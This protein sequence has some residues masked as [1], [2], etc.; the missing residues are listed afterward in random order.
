MACWS[1]SRPGDVAGA[2]RAYRE[3]LSAEPALPAARVELAV[4]PGGPRDDRALAAYRAALPLLPDDPALAHHIAWIHAEQG[5][6]LDE[7]LATRALA[8]APR[9]PAILD[10]VGYVRYRR[11][12]SSGPWIC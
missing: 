4:L 2:S 11:R 8:R 3:A 9:S 5:L 10:T 6:A 7:A 1:R 12:S